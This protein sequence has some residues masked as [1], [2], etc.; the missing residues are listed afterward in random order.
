MASFIVLTPPDREGADEKAVFIRD[1]FSFLALIFP[2]FWL[3]WYRLW[4]AAILLLAVS[5]GLA[6]TID[7]LPQWWLVS[8]TASILLSFYVALE[9]N[10]WRIAKKERQDWRLDAIVEAQ[11]VA[12]AE[13]IYFADD[14]RGA[15]RRSDAASRPDGGRRTVWPSRPE[16]AADGPALGLLDLEGK[17]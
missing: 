10:S 6:A 16:S 9:G 3:L 4:F 5:V 8:F 12:T 13:D 17:R 14:R 1:G 11:N 15:A 7:A 2:F